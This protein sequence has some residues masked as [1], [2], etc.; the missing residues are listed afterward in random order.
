MGLL[1]W[2]TR[3][4]EDPTLDDPEWPD[5]IEALVRQVCAEVIDN[6]RATVTREI[7]AGPGDCLSVIPTNPD[8]CE[9][10]VVLDYPTVS[11]DSATDEMFGDASERLECLRMDLEDVLA[12]RFEWSHR[13]S[14]RS[15]WSVTVLH[16]EFYRDGVLRRS[17]SRS[18]AEP[19]KA[20]A[21]HTF[22]PY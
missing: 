1:Q 18:G 17:F 10:F 6:G 5:R 12:G 14:G 21:R 22:A 13:Q 15:L 19:R 11:Y 9:V 7:L 8:A 2:F 16:G 3:V 20:V 4:T